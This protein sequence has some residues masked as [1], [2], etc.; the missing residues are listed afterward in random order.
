MI[1]EGVDTLDHPSIVY[2]G[3]TT[4]RRAALAAG[5]DVWEV[6]TRLRELD[7]GEEDRIDLLASETDLHPRQIRAALEFAA[8]HPEQINARIERN[9]AAIKAGRAATEARHALLG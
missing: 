1:I 3:P 9:Q 5:P 4:D 6:V 8:R 2:R 7:G